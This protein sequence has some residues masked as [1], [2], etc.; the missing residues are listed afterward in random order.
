[1]FHLEGSEVLTLLPRAV[2]SIPGGAHGHGWVLC[3]MSWGGRGEQP[4]HSRGGKWM[5]FNVPS[6]RSHSG[7]DIQVSQE[8]QW[9]GH[10]HITLLPCPAPLQRC[11]EK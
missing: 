1:M 3:S 4:A 7:I 2:V 5:S 6:N 8:G 11:V 10:E 9:P